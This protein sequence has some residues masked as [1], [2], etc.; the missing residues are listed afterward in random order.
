MNAPGGFQQSKGWDDGGNPI[1]DPPDDKGPTSNFSPAITKKIE[2]TQALGT[3][4]AAVSAGVKP[5]QAPTMTPGNYK[6]IG[7]GRKISDLEAKTKQIVSANKERTHP[8]MPQLGDLVK[9]I[10]L[11][12][13]LRKQ[14]QTQGP[15]LAKYG[16]HIRTV[17]TKF[18][19]AVTV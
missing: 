15:F 1:M 9:G 2:E 5:L 7:S 8:T 19:Q 6:I 12:P 16:I 11:V 10:A 4:V 17:Q 14:E 18:I 3:A 13:R